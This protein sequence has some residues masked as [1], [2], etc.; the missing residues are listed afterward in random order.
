MTELSFYF[1]GKTMSNTRSWEWLSK[2]ISYNTVSCNSNL[3]LIKE[4]ES[5]LNGLGFRC[6][7][8]YND[9]KTKANLLASVGPEGVPG[10]VLSGHTDV[11][12]VAGKSLLTGAN[13]INVY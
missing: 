13:D 9:E 8:F 3:D 10:I 11:V 5:F 1:G 2:L 12:P 6:Q 4:C 7:L